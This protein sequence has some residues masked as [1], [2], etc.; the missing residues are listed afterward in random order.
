MTKQWDM[1][2]GLCERMQAL[3]T[4]LQAEAQSSPPSEESLDAQAAYRA[5][6]GTLAWVLATMRTLE[7]G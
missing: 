2:R 5:S 6:R 4:D 3:Q 1:L 7:G